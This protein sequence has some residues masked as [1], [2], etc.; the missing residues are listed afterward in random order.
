MKTIFISALMLM[1]IAVSLATPNT[2]QAST[3]YA[4]EL[5]AIGTIRIVSST[6]TCTRYENPISWG[7]AGAVGPQGPQGPAGTALAYAHV[8]ADGTIDTAQTSANIVV[9]R[10]Y[11]IVD[12]SI[13]AGLYC[14]GVLGGTDGMV[15]VAVVSLDSQ[16]NAGGTVQ[17]SVFLASGCEGTGALDSNNIYVVTRPQLQDGGQNGIDR[18]FYLIVN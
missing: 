4:C 1:A 2:A 16:A 8:L 3:I 11:S 18:A 13:D 5:K 17:A 9:H 14:I 15:H 6:T 7:T 10:H 12:G